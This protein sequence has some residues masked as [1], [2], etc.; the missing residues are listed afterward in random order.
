MLSTISSVNGEPK[1]KPENHLHKFLS[2]VLCIALI[3]L[4]LTGC[5]AADWKN[6]EGKIPVLEEIALTIV[7]VAAPEYRAE[8][9]GIT[10][11]INADL[12]VIDGLIQQY[13]ANLSTA[14]AG[15]RAKIQ[16]A[17]ADLQAQQGKVEAALHISDPDTQGYFNALVDAAGIF[18]TELQSL[19]PSA[20]SSPSSAPALAFLPPAGKVKII[21]P[22]ALVKRF[23]RKQKKVHIT[24]CGLKCKIGNAIGDAASKR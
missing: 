24:G 2:L 9:Q 10:Q 15:D 11:Q 4:P 23:N 7:D 17:I 12:G 13:Q 8:V 20:T 3:A 1:L 18:V 5:S 22:A 21:T 14:S 19:L 16:A 6:V